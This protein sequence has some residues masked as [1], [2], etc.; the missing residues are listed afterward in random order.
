[1]IASADPLCKHPLCHLDYVGVGSE[2]SFHLM[3]GTDTIDQTSL[4]TVSF[5]N[6]PTGDT[7]S[8]TCGE[9]FT[10]LAKLFTQICKINRKNNGSFVLLQYGVNI[11]VLYRT[12]LC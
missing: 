2:L 10:K 7:G 11:P 6:G 8:L 5:F 9:I 4:P 12:S 3:L 1:M